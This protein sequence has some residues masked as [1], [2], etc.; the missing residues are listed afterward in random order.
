LVCL[1]V[2]SCDGGD[3]LGLPYL[4]VTLGHADAVA[5]PGSRLCDRDACRDALGDEATAK[6]MNRIGRNPAA[7]IAGS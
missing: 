6:V 7:R 2:E 1:G 3:E 4:V 5:K